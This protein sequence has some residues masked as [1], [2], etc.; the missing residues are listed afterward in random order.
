MMKMFS[1]RSIDEGVVSPALA[2]LDGSLHLDHPIK[3]KLKPLNAGEGG[4]TPA[5]W[6]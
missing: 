6:F 5:L 3:A 1:R 4:I 2:I